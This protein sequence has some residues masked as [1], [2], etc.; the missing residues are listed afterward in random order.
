MR[1]CV[2]VLE[3]LFDYVE[4]AQCEAVSQSKLR[5]LWDYPES[6]LAERGIR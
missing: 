6:Y 3:S 5:R 2:C 4:M 1:H